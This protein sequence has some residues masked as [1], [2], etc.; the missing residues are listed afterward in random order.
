MADTR[1]L[2]SAQRRTAAELPWYRAWLLHRTHRGRV[3]PRRCAV[4][5]Q[6]GRVMT[7]ED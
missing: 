3:G 4:R 7:P 5:P 6:P 1:P 2:T